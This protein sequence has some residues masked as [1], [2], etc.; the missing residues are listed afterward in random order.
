[1]ASANPLFDALEDEYIRAL[2]AGLR[3]PDEVW[4]QP[5][6]MEWLIALR[7]TCDGRPVGHETTRMR[8]R[9]G[10]RIVTLRSTLDPDV[11]LPH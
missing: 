7:L 10:E 6:E 5:E 8:V 9:F 2:E 1:M 11:A 4:L 3:T